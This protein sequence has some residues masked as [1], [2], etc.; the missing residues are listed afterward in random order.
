M[1]DRG[2]NPKFRPATGLTA[3]VRPAIRPVKASPPPPPPSPP[4]R[5]EPS[6]RSYGPDSQTAIDARRLDD[7]ERPT[8]SAVG[9]G[10]R[11]APREFVPAS[12]RSGRGNV[13]P[14][15]FDDE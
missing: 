10:P 14:L 2:M 13:V 1:G 12:P 5:P 7:Y 3:T 15:T 6:P 8:A 4:R 9:D 11:P